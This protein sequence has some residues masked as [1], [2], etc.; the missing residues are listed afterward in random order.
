M[1]RERILLADDHEAMLEEAARLLATDFDVVGTVENGELAIQAVDR[2]D[3]DIVILDIS[4]PVINGIEAACCLKQSGSRARVIFLT[5]QSHPEFVVAAFSSGALGYV[6]KT[7]LVTDLVPAVREVLEGRIF[8]SPSL[9][10]GQTAGLCPTTGARDKN[11]SSMDE[12]RLAA[13][14]DM[15]SVGVCAG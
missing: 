12:E 8:A 15:L 4:M 2:L 1:E 11:P 7:H 3:P 5:A 6:L 14:R 10:M 9:G 13:G